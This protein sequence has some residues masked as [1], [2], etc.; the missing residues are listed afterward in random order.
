MSSI[1]VSA[2]TDCAKVI[3]DL[4]KE[5]EQLKLQLGAAQDDD[6]AVIEI[7]LKAAIAA[8]L[9]LDVRDEDEVSFLMITCPK[10]RNCCS[11]IEFSDSARR[12]E[13]SLDPQCNLNIHKM[14]KEGQRLPN[15]VCWLID[16]E[17]NQG[18]SDWTINAGDEWQVK[19]VSISADCS[20]MCCGDGF[21]IDVRL[22]M[23][24]IETHECILCNDFT[25]KKDMM[26]NGDDWMCEDCHASFE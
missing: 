12:G 11:K 1:V 14:L 7:W 26:T 5:V 10:M 6:D 3:S 21:H 15:W 9:L 8:A 19:K 17:D 23:E 20:Q 24:R 22:S 2:N 16:A 18:D 13:R 25:A 4:E